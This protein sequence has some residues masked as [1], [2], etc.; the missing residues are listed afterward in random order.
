MN[1]P[2]GLTLEQTRKFLQRQV[3]TGRYMILGTVIITVVN[4][5]SLL[6]NS[7]LYISYSLDL[8]Y[9]AAWLGKYAD[10]GFLSDMGVNGHYT[11]LGLLVA[12]VLLA[13]L[14]ALWVLAKQS[15]KWIKVAM[16]LLIVDAVALAV[17]ASIYFQAGIL[18]VLWDLV[19]HIAVIWEMGRAISSE[20]MLQEL[21][22]TE[23]K[24][25]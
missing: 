23:P 25:S 12:F 1:I 18:A 7:D 8:G 6:L 2:S 3:S 16:G 24:A 15:M 5:I 14:L 22:E 17:F 9:Y 21:P 20:K 19:I 10:N 4:L 13:A 11:R